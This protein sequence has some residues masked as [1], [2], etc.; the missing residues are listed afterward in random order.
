[1]YLLMLDGIFHAT[2]HDKKTWNFIWLHGDQISVTWS[3]NFDPF[4]FEERRC[5]AIVLNL[6]LR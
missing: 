4:L 3:V 6:N 1:M 2:S 5:D